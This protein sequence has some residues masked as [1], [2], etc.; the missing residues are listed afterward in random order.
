M[1]A[2]DLADIAFPGFVLR[3]LD[4]FGVQP[5]QL[6]L[7]ITET[8]LSNDI[9][10]ALET[11][12]ILSG[13]GFRIAI[14]DFG[15]GFS[16]LAQLKRFPINVLKID[17]SFVGELDHSPGDSL[18]VRSTIDL[19]HGMGLTVVAEGVETIGVARLLAEW[20]AET[21]QGY[22]LSPPLASAAFEE[23]LASSDLRDLK[24]ATHDRS[25]SASASANRML[26]L[27]R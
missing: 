25:A 17:R 3:T 11:L 27:A 6:E 8:A 24:S 10:R 4:E 22:L 13:L 5:K 7:E 14:D 18:I 16:S 1:S 23:W 15:T 19:A 9:E 2:N 20:G 12:R 26:Q 21:L